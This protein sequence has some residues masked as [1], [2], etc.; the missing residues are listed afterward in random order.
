[1]TTPLPDI[2]LSYCREDQATARR[3]A[4]SLQREGL[5]VWWDQTLSTG[6]AYDEVT[7]RA[8]E[9]AKAVVVLWSRQSVSSRWVRAE[10]TTADRK[11]VLAPVMIEPCKRPIMFELT[12]TAELFGWNGDTND[13]KWRSFVAD[14]GRMVQ[15]GVPA[16]SSGLPS[17]LPT[18]RDAAGTGAVSRPGRS[19]WP[20]IAAGLAVLVLLSGGFWTW[21]RNSQ[22]REARE[23]VPEIAKLVDAGKLPA[24]FARAQQVR[25]LLPDDPM[26]KALVPLFTMTY[27]VTTTPPEAEVFVRGY[28]T[29][30]EQWQRLGSTP[31]ERVALPRRVLRWR[32]EK[33]G[34]ETV[35][36]ATPLLAAQ[37]MVGS[38]L[39]D[40][41]GKFDVTLKA[42]GEVPLGMVYVPE[43]TLSDPRMAPEVRVSAFFI[44]R[45]EVTNAQYKEFIEGGGYE[46]ASLWEGLD[47]G[48]DGRR[49]DFGAAIRL[50]VDATGRPGPATWELGNYPD[51]QGK[52]PVAGISWY[53]A[54]AYARFRGRSLPTA[55]HWLRAA[56]PENEI[57]V[58]LASSI[59]PL[60]NYGTTGPLPVG[61]AQ[62]LGPYGTYDMFGN[63]REWIANAGP[64]GSWV[65]GGGWEDAAY[66][67]RELIPLDR[68][69]RSRLNGL[70]LMQQIGDPPNAGVLRADFSA[71]RTIVD[72]STRRPVSDEIYATYARQFAYR[73]GPL[74][75]TEPVTMATTEDW[76]KQ[77]VTIDAGYNNEML[78]LI[79]FVPKNANPPFQ[80]VIFFSGVQIML[81]P[82]SS[83]SIEPGFAAAPIDYIVKSGR[84]LVQPIFQGTYERFKAPIDFADEVRTTREW[85]ERRWDLGRTIDYLET[86]SDFDATHTGYF[87][88][89]FGASYALPLVATEPRIKAAVLLSGGFGP[90]PVPPIVD[91]IN[92]VSRIRIPV[93]MV[94]GRF[95]YAFAVETQQRPMF[96]LLGSPAADKKHVLLD[97]GHGSPPRAEV[98]RESLGWLDK[99]L[100]PVRR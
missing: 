58:S 10:A 76:I 70:R 2:F 29:P 64:K 28:D 26:L 63:V 22:M 36:L 91:S 73:S 100:G 3:Y 31:I 47:F 61:Q 1:M 87:G 85:I 37:N 77:R 82:A 86:R 95:D 78:D 5:S 50:F 11:R 42:A 54:M 43:G 48:K 52:Y 59:A 24:A 80:P 79:L 20:A 66:S 17:N 41:A 16:G 30:D 21:Q 56:L 96:R 9:G 93:L 49:L 90:D 55:Y 57:G 83:D 12:Q 15:R 81:F 18:P 32:V 53:E 98:L 68:M 97:Y 84:V 92:Y 7:E 6:E 34:F 89:S 4:E 69:E 62:G 45:H 33:V 19:R 25:A 38:F 27:H 99:Y 44:D 14:L 46:R 13:L 75:A 39:T 72:W 60:S 71:N 94:N 8:L 23:A 74:N 40:S 88:T 65:A 35:E 51:G 67:Y